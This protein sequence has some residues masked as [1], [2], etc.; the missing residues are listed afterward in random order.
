MGFKSSVAAPEVW[1]KLVTIVD[2]IEY[3]EYILMYVDDILSVSAT[4]L[5]IMKEI[6]EMVKFKNDKFK[7]PLKYVGARPYNKNIIGFYC[8][9]ITSVDYEKAVLENVE[10]GSKIMRWK[11]PN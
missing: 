4:P 8:W 1:L 7:E 9:S 11:L 5:P 10:N 2:G 6:Q 3:Y